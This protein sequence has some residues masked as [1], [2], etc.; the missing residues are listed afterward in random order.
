MTTQPRSDDAATTPLDALVVEGVRKTFEAENAPVRALAAPTS[1]C[2]RASSSRHGPVGLRQVDAAQPRRRARR[3]RRGHDHRRR[4]A[5]HRSHRGRARA[6]AAPAHRHRVPVLQPARG[7]DGARER[8][9][10]GHHRGA[11]PQGRRDAGPAT[12]S[13]SSASATRPHRCPACSRAASA[14]A[15]RSPARWRTSRRC[16]RPT[17]RPARS[18]P[19]GARRSS[20]CSSRLHAGGQTILL[21]TH[22]AERR[23]G[24]GTVVHMRDG[25]VVA[26]TT[27]R[28]RRPA[29]SIGSL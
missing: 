4:R 10:P 12:S 1:P 29:T 20:S 13:T 17:S 14:S 16:S 11:P 2:R 28:T 26:T 3:P 23:R 22:D 5:R 25:R 27:R 19:R 7:H 21:V 24:R 15:S 9:A 6:D 18:T 8:R